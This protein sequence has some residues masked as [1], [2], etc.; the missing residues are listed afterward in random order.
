[1]DVYLSGGVASGPVIVF[2]ADKIQKLKTQLNFM[3]PAEIALR[4]SCVLP[5]PDS[6]ANPPSGPHMGLLGADP[7]TDA[8][9]AG[10]KRARGM[11]MHTYRYMFCHAY[12]LS[13]CT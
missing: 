9:R 8:D 13:T 6:I 12:A 1:M 3:G 10:L 2:N 11:H 7:N 4:D 5:S